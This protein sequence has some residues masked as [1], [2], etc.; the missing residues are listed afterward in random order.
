[1]SANAVSL[2]GNQLALLALPW[3]V[4]QT[5][6]SAARVGV[7]GAVE[8]V[9]IILSAFFSGALVDRIGFRRSSV[10]ADCAS[11]ISIA[12]IPLLYRTVGLAFWQVLLLIFLTQV[13]NRPGVTA[14]DSILPDLAEAVGIRIERVAS[15]DQSIMNLASLLGPLLA[16][17]LIATIEARNVLWIDGASFAFSALLVALL[18]PDH[19][20]TGLKAS[21]P[22]SSRSGKAC[23][24]SVASA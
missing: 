19:A 12:L 13:F 14:R 22:Y 23:A 11:G 6:G 8:G 17:V 15:L 16:G 7:A 3:F 2:A 21:A 5:T 24:F 18:I 10:L 4:L 9:A 20:R 1:M